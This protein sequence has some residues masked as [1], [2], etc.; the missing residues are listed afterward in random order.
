MATPLALFAPALLTVIVKVTTSPTLGVG[1]LTVF[2]I[3]KSEVCGVTSK[4]DSS[5]SL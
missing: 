4:L 5:S 3:L 2:S 1:S